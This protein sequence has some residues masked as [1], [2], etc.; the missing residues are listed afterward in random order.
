MIPAT[1]S[2]NLTGEEVPPSVS[3]N[4]VSREWVEQRRERWGENS[5]LYQSRVEANF[6]D[7]DDSALMQ[8]RWVEEAQARELPGEAPPIFGVDVA[9]SGTDRT[10]VV[11][12]RGGQLRVAHVAQ[13]ADTTQTTGTVARLLADAG[14][15]AGAA[16]DVIGIGA[17][18]YDSLHEQG[19]NV[20]A[21]NA[22]ERADD[23][24][25]FRNM[26]A[27]AFWRLREL[28]REGAI[29]LPADDE[30]A[31]E[32]LSLTWS[33]DSSGRILIAPKSDLPRSPDLADA[34]AMSLAQPPGAMPV[35]FAADPE[36]LEI[37]HTLRV[38]GGGDGRDL[39]TRTW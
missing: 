17:G 30:L 16:V 32:L 6:P 22:S 35:A 36:P 24:S 12:N 5:P 20:R 25:R 1:A 13:G 9:R 39:M 23:P 7:T 19:A 8:L 3:R 10:V 4:L 14:D 34:C 29:D 26:R 2:P 21:F 28:L 27:Q 11:A 38:A 18:V 37:Q 33:V 31:A 15:G